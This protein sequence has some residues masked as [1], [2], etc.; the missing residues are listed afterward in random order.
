MRR[1]AFLAAITA[2][3]MAASGSAAAAAV[4]GAVAQ[5]TAPP[6]YTRVV[7]S[8][9]DNPALSKSAGIATC[10]AHKV[11]WGGGTANLDGDP[12]AVT[13]HSTSPHGSTAWRGSIS[14]V[15]GTDSKFEVAVTCAAKPARY[16]IVSKAFANPSSTESHATVTCPA[17]TVVLSGGV[18]TTSTSVDTVV[19][20]AWPK[21]STQFVAW[22]SNGSTTN[23][24]DHVL[25]V[26]AARPPGYSL[27]SVASS[28]PP[29]TGVAI[30]QACPINTS[31]IGGGAS[32]SIK[33]PAFTLFALAPGSRTTWDTQITNS[34][35]TAAIVTAYIICAR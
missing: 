32:S 18:E 7:N 15:S 14:N 12:P 23:A 33:T 16:R 9:L 17:N 27:R 21:S 2:T 10:P 19:T 35:A 24:T 6:G 13:L 11:M 5:A 8:P 26:C 4:P 30:A 34:G 22:V 25:A 1:L 28:D 3:V 29:G 31:V 20:N